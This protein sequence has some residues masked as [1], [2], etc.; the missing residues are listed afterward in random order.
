MHATR[1]YRGGR[2][3]PVESP[4]L[5]AL[6]DRLRTEPDTY[7]WVDLTMDDADVLQRL[8]DLLSLHALAVED[9]LSENERPKLARFS[10][11]LLL[12]VTC[13]E[14]DAAGQV[15]LQRLTA[16]V[17]PDL[18]ITVRDA[19]FPIDAVGELL[20][21]N[22]DLASSGVGFIVWA[23]LDVV[24]DDHTDTVERLDDVLE[25]LTRTLFESNLDRVALQRRAFRLRRSVVR[26]QR[27]TVP[28]REVV[29]SMLRRDA[30]LAS[31]EQMRP[32]FADVYDHIIHAAESTE[33]MREQIG[34]IIDTNVALQGNRL[35]A[36]MKKVTSWAAIIAVPTAI[37]GF[38][39]QNV[40]FP[41]NGT[42]WGFWLS[43]GLIVVSIVG[44]YWM[45]RRNDWL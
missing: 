31:V 38:A 33:L 34:S 23:I 17:L 20:D 37:T 40:L 24:V 18:V 26:M 11:H 9:A 28:L 29:N 16:F 30:G 10:T 39:G 3:V 45:F 4:S 19:D 41:G 43:S 25:E 12:T 21:G 35:N 27:V 7:A 15:A 13:S 6:V 32:Y 42:V 36:I 44:L 5:H 8:A 2:R 22:E 14:S 1:V